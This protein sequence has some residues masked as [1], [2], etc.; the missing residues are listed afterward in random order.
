MQVGRYHAEWMPKWGQAGEFL[1]LLD[2]DADFLAAT[3]PEAFKNDNL[4][5]VA[6]LVDGKDFLCD[7]V[8]SNT[9][10]TRSQYSNKMKASAF[11]CLSW[12]TAAGLSFE[13]TD[14]FN[15]RCSENRLVELWGP[16]MGKIPKGWSVLADRGFSST[17]RFY[18]NFNTQLTPKFLMRRL[19]FEESEVCLDMVLCRLRY[20][21]EVGFARV[22]TL[23]G[24]RDR[25]SYKM[26]QDVDAMNH[27]GHAMV[28]L[29]KPLI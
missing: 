11:R 22:T 26:F 14:L 21:C 6:A 9:M 27:W 4:E 10:T 20:H 8:R 15:G 16:R 12:M 1:S 23:H 5:K 13:H 29:M 17:G 2:I 19:Q 25:I 3:M 18:P 24:L 7:T 28:N